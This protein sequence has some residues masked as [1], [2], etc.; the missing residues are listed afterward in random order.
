M[1]QDSDVAFTSVPETK[2]TLSEDAETCFDSSGLQREPVTVKGRRTRERVLIAAREVFARDGYVD[3]RMSDIA[4]AASISNGAL[5][6]YFKDKEA[7]FAALIGDLHEQLYASSGD[8]EHDFAAA[9]YDALLDANAGYLA[10]YYENRDVMRAFMQAAAVDARF[11]TIWWDMRQRHVQRFVR[12][13]RAA[14][15][16]SRIESV[17]VAIAT[18]ALACMVEQAAYVWFAHEG[19]NRRAVSV[20]EAARIV[21]RAWYRMF[22]P[23][24]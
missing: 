20:D 24:D 18:D 22:F 7:V 19:L 9:P 6:R 1:C 10:L 23:P 5:Y 17:D 13:V 21:T 8:T 2:S 12:A 16:I 3:A 4:L 15:R 14:H 11:R